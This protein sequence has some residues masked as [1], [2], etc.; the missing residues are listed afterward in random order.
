MQ[1]KLM[2]VPSLVL[3][4][5]GAF[6]GLSTGLAQAATD[7]DRVVVTVRRGAEK[8]H[9]N[10]RATCPGIEAALARSLGVAQARHQ[11]EGTTTVAFR[12]SGSAISEIQQRG[13]P[14]EYR[15]EVRR[16]VRQ[17][18]CNAEGQDQLYVMQLVFLNEEPSSDPA[19]AVRRMA[20]LD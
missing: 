15:T 5:A 17:L 6:A 11:R 19:A 1:T 7:L 4:L 14:M 3:V 9:T 16:A 12:L 8:I 2:S 20:L 10:V 13:G 18:A